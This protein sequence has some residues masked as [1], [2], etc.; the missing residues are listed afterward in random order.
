MELSSPRGCR[1]RFSHQYG[2]DAERYGSGAAIDG[3]E[4][5]RAFKPNVKN[6]KISSVGVGQ[7]TYITKEFHWRNGSKEWMN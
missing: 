5:H 7:V 4:N 2:T 6:P 1:Y 3:I